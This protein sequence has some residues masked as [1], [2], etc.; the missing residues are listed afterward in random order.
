M[1]RNYRFH[2]PEAPYFVSFSVVEWLD[3]FT[4]NEYKDILI[5]SL[6]YCQEKKGMEIYAWCIMSNH[7]HIVFRSTNGIPP[8]QLLGSFKRH[9][10][11]AV[12]KAIKENDRESRRSEEHTSELQSRPHLVCRLL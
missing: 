1:S 5:D 7:V 8:G 10:S 3:V 12:V 6:H 11:M 9:T 4:R 2:N